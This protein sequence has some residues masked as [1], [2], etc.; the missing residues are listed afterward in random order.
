M[1]ADLHL[2][3]NFSDGTYTPEELVSHAKRHGFGALAL[4]D[5]DTVEG[6]E[7][8]GRA[9]AAAGIEFIAGTELTAEQDGNELHILGYLVDL[10]DPKFLGEIVKFQAVRQNRIREMVARLNQIQVPLKVEAV[11]ALANCK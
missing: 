1:Y 11:F 3:T 6:C 7:R 9:C 4:T 8:A 10:H 2:H 5:H